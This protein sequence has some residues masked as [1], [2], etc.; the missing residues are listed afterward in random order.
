MTRRTET[1]MLSNRH[2]CRFSIR[3]GGRRVDN[4]LYEVRV[5]AQWAP[6][7]EILSLLPLMTVHTADV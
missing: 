4:Q 3:G 6:S 5:K 1:A 2:C 7:A